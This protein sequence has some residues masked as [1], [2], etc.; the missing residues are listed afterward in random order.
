[1]PGFPMR[2]SHSAT[3]E[4]PIPPRPRHQ[5]DIHLRGGDSAQNTL[6]CTGFGHQHPGTAP[7]QVRPQQVDVTVPA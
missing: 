4:L 6:S 2:W 1:M 7:A 5:R 3:P